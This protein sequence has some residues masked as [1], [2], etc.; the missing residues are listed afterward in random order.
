[1]K[2]RGSFFAGLKIILPIILFLVILNWVI[3][4]LFSGIEAIE[5][6]FPDSWIKS[7]NL[8][9]IAVKLLGLFI[10]FVVVWII[11]LISRQPK[12]SKRIQNW[13]K[14]IVYRIPLLSHLFK[15]TNQVADTLQNSSSFK[16][17]VLVR[18]PN[19]KSLAVGFVTN[20]KPIQHYNMISVVVL[21]SPP[22]S[23]FVLLVNSKDVV[24]TNISVSSALSFVVSMGVAG[25]TEKFINESCS[26]WG[27]DFFVIQLFVLFLLCKIVYS[28]I[29]S[30]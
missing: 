11:G 5:S 9:E 28:D 12:M 3:G 22:T 13:L 4:T 24:E 10:L 25:A 8:P 7:L 19:D 14:P 23:S 30:L 6:L 29:E 18:F 17:V 20:E 2:K 27:R 16:R 26:E 1:M 21:A 15:I